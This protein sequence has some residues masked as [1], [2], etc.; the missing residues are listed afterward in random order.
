MNLTR[1]QLEKRYYDKKHAD[2]KGI[3]HGRPYTLY[4]NPSTGG[5]ESWPVSAIPTQDLLRGF[6]GDT[7]QE[8]SP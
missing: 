1:T 6:P 4:L 3:Y 2:Y 5:T 7:C 8:E